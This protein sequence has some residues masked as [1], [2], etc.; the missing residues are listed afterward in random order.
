MELSRQGS[1]RARI[2]AQVSKAQ[3]QDCRAGPKQGKQAGALWQGP[4]KSTPTHMPYRTG[5][6]IHRH[7]DTCPT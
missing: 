6:R 2:V 4:V 7:T 1:I 3:V 5:E